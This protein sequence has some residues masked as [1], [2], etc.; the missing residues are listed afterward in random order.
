MN[1]ILVYISLFFVSCSSVT[2]KSPIHDSVSVSLDSKSTSI[3]INS[4]INKIS[5][6]YGPLND[7]VVI[8]SEKKIVTPIIAIHLAPAAYH[9]SAYIAL[10]KSLEKRKIKIAVISAEGFSSV[11]AALY[12]KYES[13]KLLEWKIY[14]LFGLLS[15]E[16][17]LSQAWFTKLD[18]FLDDEFKDI[19]M[20]QLPKLFL[21]PEIIDNKIH[22]IANQEVR[23]AVKNSLMVFKSQVNSSLVSEQVYFNNEIKKYCSADMIFHVGVLQDNLSWKESN[24]KIKNIYDKKFSKINQVNG[25]FLLLDSINRPIDSV[26]MVSEVEKMIFKSSETITHKI[27][28][29]IQKWREN[30]N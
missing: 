23:S 19:K 28:S 15:S 5:S 18:D 10:F 4:K 17:Y 2:E 16:K 3:N 24:E 9:S 22:L 8:K 7:V 26:N 20:N 12:A 13:S 6:T 21:L 27:Q 14:K 1:L 29:V 30:Y 25:E 11:I